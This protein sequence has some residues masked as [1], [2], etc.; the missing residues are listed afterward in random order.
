MALGGEAKSASPPH[1]PFSK[2]TNEPLKG[3]RAEPREPWCALTATHR[4]AP[5]KHPPFSRPLT[6]CSSPH[7]LS[8]NASARAQ[9]PHPS[10]HTHDRTVHIAMPHHV[11]HARY[12]THARATACSHSSSFLLTACLTV[13]VARVNRARSSEITNLATF[14]QPSLYDRR[15][16]L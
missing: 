1:P 5:S 8:S 2:V 11:A 14:N 16:V 13:W 6:L 12:F 3:L 9:L 7:E 10:T 4:P 15:L